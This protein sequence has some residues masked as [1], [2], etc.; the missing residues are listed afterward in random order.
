MS[1]NKSIENIPESFE[2]IQQAGAFWDA[3][4]LAD[5]EKDTKP[6]EINFNITKRTRYISV[7][8]T[9]YQKISKN[10]RAKHLSVKNLV[11]SLGK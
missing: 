10:A 1:V 5:Y 8:E 2:S 7:P 11:Y 4:S 3:H 6:V 9:I